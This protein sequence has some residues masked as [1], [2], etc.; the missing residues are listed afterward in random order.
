M[1]TQLIKTRRGDYDN[2]A[3]D[4]DILVVYG[5]VWG[6]I[7]NCNTIVIINGDI[8]GDVRDCKEVVGLPGDNRILTP[9]KKGSAET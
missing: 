9:P 2:N 7:K 8:K 6:N 3:E 1:G 4:M 5:D